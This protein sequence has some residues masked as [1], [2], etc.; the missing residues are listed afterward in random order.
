[1][2]S[3]QTGQ[4]AATV[5]I[6][7]DQQIVPITV[8]SPDNN[9]AIIAK[10]AFRLHGGLK[11][12]PETRAKYAIRLGR[13]ADSTVLLT[14]VPL[15][16][17]GSPE[18][19]PIRGKDVRRATLLACDTAVERLT[20]Q[21]GFFSGQLVYVNH[22]G[23]I[24]ELYTSDLFFQGF[25]KLTSHRFQVISPDWSPDGSKI[26]Y[27]SNHRGGLDIY[28]LDVPSR[29]PRVV[30]SYRGQNHGASF[31]PHGR[32]AAMILN[33]EVFIHS[34][35][36]NPNVKPTRVSHNPS[37]ETCPTWSPSG[38]E[39]VVSSDI[40]GGAKLFELMLS[41]RN[42]G[43]M[44]PIPI[45]VSRECTE[46][47]WNPR[48][49]K[50]LAFTANIGGHSQ[51]AVYNFETKQTKVIRS[52]S[53]DEG[54]SWANDGRHIVYSSQQ[55]GAHQLKICDFLTD[56]QVA[57]HTRTSGNFSSPDFFYPKAR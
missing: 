43:R 47:T 45:T 2:V 8:Q 9:M 25:K 34:S 57:L 11:M 29:V 50:L 5:D 46:P 28:M 19:F 16:G 41:G 52:S 30:A 35:I 13:R 4:V 20:G 10:Q 51:I 14:I 21:P 12:V 18:S 1:M 26:L 39:M 22:S 40:Q 15:R 23:K 44:K 31:G 6:D 37:A 3:G 53:N 36:H 54:P 38:R 17:A 33:R 48:D 27:S 42:K 49:A 24:R 32:R 55:G 56:K 7:Y